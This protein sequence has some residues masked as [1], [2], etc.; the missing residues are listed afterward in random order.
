MKN[1]KPFVFLSKGTLYAEVKMHNLE[2][3]EWRIVNHRDDCSDSVEKSA[4]DECV[5]RGET[6]MMGI[7]IAEPIG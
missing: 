7:T 4:Y 6:I 1:Q 5:S 2:T 3:G